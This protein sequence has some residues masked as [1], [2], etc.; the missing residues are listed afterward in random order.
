MMAS[1][2][3]KAN[4]Q[5][6]PSPFA[7]TIALDCDSQATGGGLEVPFIFTAKALLPKW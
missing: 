1:V 3:N 6:Q 7:Q 2:S 5:Q 4:R